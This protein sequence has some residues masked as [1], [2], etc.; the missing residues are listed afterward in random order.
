MNIFLFNFF[1]NKE[2]KNILGIKNNLVIKKKCMFF[3]PFKI[4]ILKPQTGQAYQAEAHQAEA[5]VHEIQTKKKR[6][7]PKQLHP[8]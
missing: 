2:N 8:K 7:K 4:F 5:Q 6:A 1:V 3:F